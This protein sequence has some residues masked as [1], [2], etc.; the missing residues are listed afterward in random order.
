MIKF[1][2]LHKINAR[3]EREF[4]QSFTAFLNS[5]YYVLGNETTRFEQEFAKYCGTTFCIGISN[6]LDAIRL[7]FEAYK[8]LGALKEGDEVIVPANTYI[9]SML[10][11][12]QSGLVPVLVEPDED[13]FNISPANVKKAITEKTKA[14]MAVHL[15]GQ[16]APMEEL[17]NIANA[18][19][20]LLLEDAAQ[21]H[22]ATDNR[23]LRA[24]NLSDAAA[25]S[26]YPT[27]NLGALGEAGAVTTNHEEL[28][29]VI[30]ELRNY[31][32]LTRYH[33]TYKGLNARIDEVQCGVLNIKLPFLDADN[34]HRRR[35]ALMYLDGIT[36]S[37]IKLPYYS[38]GKDHI[39]H[40]F[41]IRCTERD[42]LKEYLEQH[43]VQTMIHYPVPP[44]KQQAYAEWNNLSFP[45][46]ESIHNEILSLPI[47]PVI[48]DEEVNTVINIINRF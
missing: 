42:H 20:V 26:F 7:I 23:G 10:G 1:L 27:K 8:V 30:R 24:G 21:A 17:K 29:R 11:V 48:V 33:H 47:S 9:A 38:G 44:H 46:T 22:G 18:H 32:S 41:V 15:Y 2:D 37:K 43:G 35:V 31:G 39:F 28:N 4:Q 3:F 12:S 13:P 36:N 5:G 40:L 14:I 45:I 34:E 19:N 25:F 16:L 6:G